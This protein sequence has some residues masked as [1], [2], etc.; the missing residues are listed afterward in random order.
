M[1]EQ[2]SGKR[3][4]EGNQWKNMKKQSL[5]EFLIQT[6]H[7]LKEVI[8]S[9]DSV[10]YTYELLNEETLIWP[11]Q[12]DYAVI[13]VNE[14]REPVHDFWTMLEKTSQIPDTI[15]PLRYQLTTELIYLDDQIR[16]LILMIGNFRNSCQTTSKEAVRQRSAILHKLEMVL[17]SKEDIAQRSERLFEQ[18]ITQEQG[19]LT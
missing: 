14:L 13:S 11:D 3:P 6:R 9:L 4:D 5:V 10:Q 12:C 19:L 1:A 16:K 7:Y 17:E 2:I 8:T 15:I 18:A